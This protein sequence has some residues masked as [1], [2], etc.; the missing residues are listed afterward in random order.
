MKN[1]LLI[2]C[3]NGVRL[4]ESFAEVFG[5]QGKRYINLSAPGFGNRY[6]RARLFEYVE[7]FGKP[8]FAYLQFSGLSRIDLPFDNKANLGDY[9]YKVKT[10][11][12]QW[13]ASGGRNGTWLQNDR[14]KRIFAY[15]YDIT[16]SV[17]HYDLSLQE[18][19]TAVEFCDRNKIQHRWTSYY[20]YCNPPSDQTKIDG[21]IDRL[22]DYIDTTNHIGS[23]PLN[24]AYDLGDGSHDG[25]HY[26]KKI[27]KEFFNINKH[28]MEG[29]ING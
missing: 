15:L 20:D 13:V 4:E 1:I 24:L 12:R 6:I 22:P 26:S 17:Q 19:F 7:E 23:F 8:D 3:S 29:A 25:V 14:L 5:T 21:M 28:E 18:I 9:E 11:K 10:K 16:E 27:K 2:G